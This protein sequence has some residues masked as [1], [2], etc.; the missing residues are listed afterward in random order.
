MS[1]MPENWNEY[2]ICAN[3]RPL[4][5][6]PPLWH[7]SNKTPLFC[8]KSPFFGAFWGK[9]WK[10]SNTPPLKKPQSFIERRP[11]NSVNSGFCIL[12]AWTSS[13]IFIFCVRNPAE[14]VKG[15]VLIRWEKKTFKC[16]L[17]GVILTSAPN[18]FF[19]FLS[20]EIYIHTYLSTYFFQPQSSQR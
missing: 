6:S 4:L 2:R 16:S 1:I 7:N 12:E 8:S 17:Q 13:V 20:R 10:N 18:Y 14:Q 11:F 5:T 19:L 3:K 9:N 15:G